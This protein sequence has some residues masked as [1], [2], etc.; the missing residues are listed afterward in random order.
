MLDDEMLEDI[1]RQIQDFVQMQPIQL[2]AEYAFLGWAFST[3]VGVVS[4][5]QPDV[6]FLEV[7][8]P[9]VSEW[10]NQQETKRDNRKFITGLV[11]DVAREIGAL[12]RQINRYVDVMT[13]V[14]QERL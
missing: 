14:E 4:T 10:L 2:P 8:R 5:V 12:P 7:G 1:Q 6:D 11:R 3:V 13:G 9:V